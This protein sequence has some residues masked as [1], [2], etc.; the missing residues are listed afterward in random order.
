MLKVTAKR[1][2][3]GLETIGREVIGECREEP[4][5]LLDR[6]AEILAPIVIKESE[7]INHDRNLLK[8]QG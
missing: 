1:T 3:A 4:D 5:K 2:K 8:R 6:L 7:M